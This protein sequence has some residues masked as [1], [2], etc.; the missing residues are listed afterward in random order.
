MCDSERS[1]L[2]PDLPVSEGPWGPALVSLQRHKGGKAC[3]HL[4]EGQ[5]EVQRRDRTR[6]RLQ[7]TPKFPTPL[8]TRGAWA[9]H[10]GGVGSIR[11]VLQH[12]GEPEVG[13]LADQVAVDQ[14]VAG[15]QIAVDIAQVRE[16]AHASAHASEH[17]HQLHDGE[18]AVVRLQRNAARASGRLLEAHQ[19]PPCL[20]SMLVSKVCSHVLSTLPV[21]LRG[22]QV[23]C[24]DWSS[25][26][27]K[28]RGRPREVWPC[29]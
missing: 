17:A 18:L 16:V 7:A 2:S 5:T 6:P 21:T 3:T 26:L 23:G 19:G 14:D 28:G 20:R 11:V 4:T 15:G 25:T 13:H 24:E 27:P 9:T 12:P 22:R 10:R 29:P 8:T 1:Q